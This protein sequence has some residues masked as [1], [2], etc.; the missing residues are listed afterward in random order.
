MDKNWCHFAEYFHL[1]DAISG[2]ETTASIAVSDRKSVALPHGEVVPL[3]QWVLLFQKRADAILTLA[4]AA[5][6]NQFL[7]LFDDEFGETLE[8]A[9]SMI[10]S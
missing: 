7:L 10:S 4:E 6:W 2:E 8:I 1:G 3:D 5:G 9:P